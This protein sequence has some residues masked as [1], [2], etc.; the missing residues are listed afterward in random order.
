MGKSRIPANEMFAKS[1]RLR[2]VGKRIAIK[3]TIPGDGAKV[4]EKTRIYVMAR[5]GEH[6][7]RICLT[8][9]IGQGGEGS[10]FETDSEGFVAKIFD[11]EHRTE[12]RK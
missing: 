3:G 9:K 6:S 7:R 11:K 8:K 10:V 12:D 4:G 5:D 1:S 2:A